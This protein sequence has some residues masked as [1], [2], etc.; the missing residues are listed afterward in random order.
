MVSRIGLAGGYG[1]PSAAIEK[2]FHE[3]RVNYL[4]ISFIKRYSERL[5]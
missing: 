4:W 1:V 5:P 3:H 2:S